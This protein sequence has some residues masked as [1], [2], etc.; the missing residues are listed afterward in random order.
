MPVAFPVP[1]FTVFSQKML[2]YVEF[3]TLAVG[4]YERTARAVH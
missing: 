4:L 2:K 3:S 1:S